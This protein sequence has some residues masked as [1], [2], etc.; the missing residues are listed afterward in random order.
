MPSLEMTT[1]ETAAT[2]IVFSND[3]YCV[4]DLLS[5]VLREVMMHEEVGCVQMRKKKE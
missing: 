2:M 1:A 3:Q 4:N 5:S